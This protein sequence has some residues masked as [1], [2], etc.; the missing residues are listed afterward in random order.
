[1]SPGGDARTAAVVQVVDLRVPLQR[2]EAE[3]AVHVQ[4]RG[5]RHPQEDL[6][7]AP[8]V[9]V[10]ERPG[11]G[12]E[13]LGREARRLK[14]VPLDG[15][16]VEGRHLGLQQGAVLP[17]HL[18]VAAGQLHH[19]D[20]AGPVQ[21]AA[22][23]LRGEFQPRRRHRLRRLHGQDAGRQ[24]ADPQAHSDDSAIHERLRFQQDFVPGSTPSRNATDNET[25]AAPLRP[26]IIA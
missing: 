10:V 25:T 22:L 15:R 11:D 20:V 8:R 7:V 17:S 3:L 26:G 23:E 16:L 2:V 18:P 14:I 9:A 13:A 12:V 4:A 21:A 24:Q 19:A 5:L 1:V 6:L